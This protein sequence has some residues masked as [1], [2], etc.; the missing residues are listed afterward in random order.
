[1][2]L[3]AVGEKRGDERGDLLGEPLSDDDQESSSAT[4]SA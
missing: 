2:P 3:S 4:F 1:M